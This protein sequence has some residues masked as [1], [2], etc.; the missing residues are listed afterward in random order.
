MPSI[1]MRVRTE[2]ARYTRV[3]S[4]G[5]LCSRDE[6]RNNGSR[7]QRSRMYNGA[8]RGHPPAS[9]LQVVLLMRGIGL[10]AVCSSLN[11]LATIS[12]KEKT[13]FWP[14]SHFSHL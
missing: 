10:R 8:E 3:F 1:V 6:R 14:D 12:G 2:G 13:K 5:S 7:V 11:G 4:K 9:A